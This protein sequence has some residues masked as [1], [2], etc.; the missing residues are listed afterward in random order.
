[1]PLLIT[2]TLEVVEVRDDSIP[3]YAILSHTWGDEEISLEE[4][5]SLGAAELYVVPSTPDVVR[6]KTGL[7]KIRNSARLARE[8]GYRYLCIDT[9]CIDKSSSAELSE[10]INSMYRWYEGAAICYAY[11]FDAENLRDESP[12]QESS[13]FRR[14]KWFTRGWTLQ[15]LIA[16]KDVKK[17]S[18]DNFLQLLSYITGVDESVLDGSARLDEISVASRM[19]WA[20]GRVTTRVEDIAYCL[21]GIFNV[22]M[23]LLYGEG[24]KAFIRLQEEIL[25][26]SNDQSLF[27]WKGPA[28]AN[29]NNM[30]SGLL[31]QSPVYYQDVRTLL[32]PTSF[33]TQESFPSSMTNQER[34]FPRNP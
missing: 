10:A 16:S 21:V 15:E 12:L 24:E 22:N 20:S 8:D 26:S 1:M 5:G 19:K 7:S 27:A 30:P 3:E 2:L 6:G 9:C 33:Q 31:A 18:E 11:L 23:P 29:G 28:T 25:K 32:P 4:I 13:T 14:S 34:T 17:I